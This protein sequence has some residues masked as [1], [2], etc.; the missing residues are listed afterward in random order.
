S[1]KTLSDLGLIRQEGKQYIVKDGD[2]I[3]FKFNV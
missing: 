3:F 2:C 1:E